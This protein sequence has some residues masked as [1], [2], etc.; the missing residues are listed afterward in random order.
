MPTPKDKPAKSEGSLCPP[1]IV[2][3]KLQATLKPISLEVAL[4]IICS[5]EANFFVKWP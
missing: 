4:K 2:A 3:C 1:W 5:H